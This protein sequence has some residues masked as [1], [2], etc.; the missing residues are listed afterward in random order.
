M[1]RPSQPDGM[2]RFEAKRHAL[3]RLPAR[4]PT[5]RGIMRRGGIEAKAGD[6]G[7]GVTASS[8]DRNPFAASA[9]AVGAQFC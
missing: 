7:E 5:A 4:R 1:E 8:V 2:S 6:H 3:G 9:T